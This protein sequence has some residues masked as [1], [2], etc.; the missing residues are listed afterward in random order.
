VLKLQITNMP[1]LDIDQF[2]I[3]NDTCGH[4]AGDE[5]LRQVSTLLKPNYAKLIFWRV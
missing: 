1:Y 3:V 4:L 2:K 5:L